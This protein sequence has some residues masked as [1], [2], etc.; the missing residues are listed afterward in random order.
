MLPWVD[1]QYTIYQNVQM[2]PAHTSMRM[3]QLR[4]SVNSRCQRACFYCRPSGE[5]VPTDPRESIHPEDLIL[6]AAAC[7]SH[8]IT[9]IKLT[10][11]DP[12][13]WAPLANVVRRLKTETGIKEVQ[14]ISRN[15]RIGEMITELREAGLDQLNLSLDTLNQS[16][17]H[18]ITGVDDLPELLRALDKAATA[19][20]PLKV[21]VVVMSGIN[22]GEI[23]DII[24][25]CE[26]SGVGELKLLD[27]IRDLGDGKENNLFRLRG[28]DQT[29]RDLFV[30]LG[31]MATLLRDRAESW[32]LLNQGGLGHPMFA[33]R[34]PSGLKVI[35]KDHAAGAW[36]GNICRD[37]KFYP[38][39]DALMALRITADLRLQLCLLRDDLS[40]SIRPYIEQGLEV[41]REFIGR[42][43][44]IYSEAEYTPG[45]PQ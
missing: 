25:F 27:V 30:P 19:G 13:L 40:P 29:L 16:L 3:P 28:A 4:V 45:V 33:A 35:V 26:S 43:I 37:C 9:S 10:G 44:A 1:H 21:N 31:P 8:G 18:K 22:D 38:C 41:L 34:M 42:Q 5:G 15:P 7:A 6:V 36:Y 14:V 39:H 23:V 2:T 24:E 12:A 20:I 11:G 17:H 32:E